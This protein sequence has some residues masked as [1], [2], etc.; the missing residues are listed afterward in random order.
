MRMTV[1]GQ[2]LLTEHHFAVTRMVLLSASR[3]L[4]IMVLT[5]LRILLLTVKSV[6]RLSGRLSLKDDS[7]KRGTPMMAVRSM[8]T[9]GQAI[10][11]HLGLL[12]M[13]RLP[14]LM[15]LSVFAS[16]GTSK[17]F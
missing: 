3:L 10:M 5:P 2:I 15:S 16:V 1:V 17:R 13:T 11:S 7:C 12:I 9:V 6:L 4:R 14:N 8:V